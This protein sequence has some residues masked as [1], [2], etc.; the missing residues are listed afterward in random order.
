MSKLGEG[1][2]SPRSNLKGRSGRASGRARAEATRERMGRHLLTGL[3][4]SFPAL[5]KA[6]GASLPHPRPSSRPSLLRS[7]QQPVM[8]RRKPGA[9]TSTS[10]CATP[11]APV[12]CIRFMCSPPCLRYGL[13]VRGLRLAGGPAG[14]RGQ[15]GWWFCSGFVLFSPPATLQW[16]LTPAFLLFN[17]NLLNL[18][19]M[20]LQRPRPQPTQSTCC[21]VRVCHSGFC[22]CHPFQATV[23]PEPSSG[24]FCRAYPASHLSS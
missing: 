21:T 3:F 22:G 16:P 13:T 24:I 6:T 17:R 23:T 8:M 4:S 15:E 20:L 7:S 12:R 11:M 9:A 19:K 14:F 5:E 18:L 2:L 10:S 1:E